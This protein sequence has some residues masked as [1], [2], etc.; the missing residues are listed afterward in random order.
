MY[1]HFIGQFGPKYGKKPSC[2]PIRRLLLLALVLA[3]KLASGER[4]LL[5]LVFSREARVIHCGS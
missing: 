4:S 3:D 1:A 5:T 2:Y